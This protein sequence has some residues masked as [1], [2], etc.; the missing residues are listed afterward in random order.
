M[1]VVRGPAGIA[2]AFVTI[3]EVPRLDDLARFADALRCREAVA[4][5]TDTSSCTVSPLRKA[6]AKW[7]CAIVRIC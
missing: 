1:R 7:L 2:C 3:S 4:A 6:A 5:A